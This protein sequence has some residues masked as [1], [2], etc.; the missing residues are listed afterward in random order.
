MTKQVRF[1]AELWLHPGAGGW[2]FVTLPPQVTAKVRRQSLITRRAW[3]AVKVRAAIG[4]ASWS[5]SLFPDQR[6]GA[7][8]LPVKRSVRESEGLASESG[9]PLIIRILKPLPFSSDPA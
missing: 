2:H 1:A 6:R 8:L 7:Y 9:F 4:N 5:T 3:G